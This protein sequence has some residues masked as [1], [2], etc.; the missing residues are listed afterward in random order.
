MTRIHG[1]DME[2]IEIPLPPLLL[3]NKIVKVLDKF[4]VLLADTKG[5]LPEE[6]KQRQ[7]QYE[8]YREKLLTFDEVS[9]RF[10]SIRFDS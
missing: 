6:I 4:Q 1:D 3:Q 5:L 9:D 7:K 8:Y 2:K 10:D